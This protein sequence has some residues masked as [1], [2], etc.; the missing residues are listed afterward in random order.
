MTGSGKIGLVTVLIEE[1]LRDEIPVLSID[2][3][4]FA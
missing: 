1:T 3:P 2:R 4:R